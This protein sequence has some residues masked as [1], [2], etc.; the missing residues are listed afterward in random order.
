M[1]RQLIETEDGSHSFY[2]PELDEHFHSTHGAIQESQHVFIES[3]LKQISKKTVNIFEAGFGT[4]LNALLSIIESDKSG[5]IIH[6]YGI[7][8]YP[9]TP[10]EYTRLNY[11][12][13]TGFDCHPTFLSMHECPWEKTLKLSA[14]FSFTKLQNDLTT[15][16]FDG[17]PLFDLVYYD[18]FAPNKQGDMWNISIFERIYQH[19]AP[20]AILVTYCARGEVRR[21]LQAVGFQTEKIPGPPGKREML[22]AIK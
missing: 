22:R 15:Y 18:A 8:K 5:Q 9:L 17:C 20:G 6:Y 3:G 21:T 12:S 1:K 7:E 11:S 10:D 13:L 4:G 2:L 14:D 19:C 16:P